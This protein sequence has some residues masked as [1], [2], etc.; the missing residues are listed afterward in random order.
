MSSKPKKALKEC[1]SSRNWKWGTRSQACTECEAVAEAS[2]QSNLCGRNSVRKECARNL[3]LI[4]KGG[5]KDTAGLKLGSGEKDPLKRVS[6]Q[7]SH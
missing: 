3:H 7:K 6:D 4:A 2:E 1:G 5:E